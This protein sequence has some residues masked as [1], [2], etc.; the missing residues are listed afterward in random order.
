MLEEI[1]RTESQIMADND[2]GV[3]HFRT[4]PAVYASLFTASSKVGGYLVPAATEEEDGT[5]IPE[6]QIE[7]VQGRTLTRNAIPSMEK[8]S[9]GDFAFLAI[10]ESRMTPAYAALVAPA[11]AA[12]VVTQL[13]KAEFDLAKT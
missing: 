12:G 9:V 10:P 3:Y 5:P 6:D 1:P 7:W 2:G 13:T 8:V 4:T 11:L